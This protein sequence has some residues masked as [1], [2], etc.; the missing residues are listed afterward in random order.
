MA[1]FGTTSIGSPK[2]SVRSASRWTTLTHAAPRVRLLQRRITNPLSDQTPVPGSALHPHPQGTST[3]YP[4]LLLLGLPP[5]Q[6]QARGLPLLLLEQ[7]AAVHSPPP[8]VS[9][10]VRLPVQ[11]LARQPRLQI[12]T[13]H[14]IR[15]TPFRPPA[16]IHRGPLQLA[17]TAR[18]CPRHT[19]GAAQNKSTA[20]KHNEMFEK[21]VF[22]S[23]TA[24]AA[25]GKR[26]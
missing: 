1:R 12:L 20:A 25:E 14:L 7:S 6:T 8:V 4:R 10:R 2:H 13:H 17:I 16:Y 11:L 3:D 21:P 9:A 5:G 26:R 19:S 23:Q 15:R 24:L 22:L 18:A